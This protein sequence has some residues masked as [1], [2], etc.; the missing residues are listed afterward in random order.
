MTT[1]QLAPRAAHTSPWTWLAAAVG[2]AAHLGAGI[3]VSASGLMMP[4]WAVVGLFALWVVGLVLVVRWRRQPALVLLVG[5]TMAA[6]WLLTGT[7]GEA[8]LG[9][10][11]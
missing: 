8:L 3:L 10:T 9:W 1:T 6:I 11:G 4:A 2:M 5:P 7:L